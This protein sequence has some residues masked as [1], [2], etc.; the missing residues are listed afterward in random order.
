MTLAATRVSYVQRMMGLLFA[1]FILWALFGR[2]SPVAVQSVSRVVPSPRVASTSPAITDSLVELGLA[3]HIVGR[4]PFCRTI[5]AAIPVVGDLRDFDAERIGLVAPEVL[6]VQPPLA[7]VDPALRRVCEEQGIK[8]V[9][10]RLDSLADLGLLLE[11]I[12]GV[13]EPLPA[14][15]RTQLDSRLAAVRTFL[16]TKQTLDQSGETAAIPRVFLVVSADP[17]LAVGTGNYLHELL[18]SAGVGNQLNRPGYVELSAESMIAAKPAVIIGISDGDAG[19]ERIDAM[20]RALPW[21]EGDAP[22]I[23]ARA[24]PELLSPS[25]A[26]IAK[27]DELRAI[28]EAAR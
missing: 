17:F 22:R 28:V 20:L 8:V 24:V 26:A 9:A 11:D 18:E 27:R 10:R 6:F 7:G 3:E 15:A 19:A 21:P 4:S 25:L 12:V 5:P 16:A 13:F 23:A 2:G 14:P 1:T